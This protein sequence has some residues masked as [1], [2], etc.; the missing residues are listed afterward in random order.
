LFRREKQA[1]RLGFVTT[2][3]RLSGLT[4]E[5]PETAVFEP[6]HNFGKTPV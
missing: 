4:I 2:L 1:V 5:A 3:T 6:V